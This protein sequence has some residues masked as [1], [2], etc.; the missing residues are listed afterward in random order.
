MRCPKFLRVLLA[1]QNALALFCLTLC[2]FA[3]WQFLANGGSFNPEQVMQTI[4]QWGWLGKLVYAGLLAIAVVFSP[5]PGTPLTVAAGAIWNPVTAAMFGI[6]G[7]FGG[8]LLAYFLGRTLGR[9]IIRALTGKMIYLSKHR[10]EPY[11]GWLVFFSHLF[12]VVPFDLI[13]YGSGMIRLSFPLYAASTLLGTIPG[14]LM[15]THL[16]S[17]LKLNPWVGGAIA[18]LFIL[19]LVIL[20]WGIK[21]HNWFG[22]RE[23]VRIEE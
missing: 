13:S 2:L 21:R 7:V 11:L 1:P 19:L 22:I 3:G 17:N 6:L 20:P 10:G 9:S 5:I 18:I 14:T 4:G 8:S 23:I 15:L 12:P 16:G